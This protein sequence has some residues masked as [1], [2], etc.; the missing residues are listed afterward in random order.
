MFASAP[1][2]RCHEP[3]LRVARRCL[4]CRLALRP[5][6]AASRDD[7]GRLHRSA[8]ILALAA[9]SLLCLGSGGVVAL[10]Y[11][12]ARALRQQLG[13]ER[14]LAGLELIR[15]AQEQWRR[16]N[17]A[18]ASLTQLGDLGLLDPE[19]ISGLRDGY[20][21]E[22]QPLREDPSQ[23]WLGVATPL[24]GVGR[25]FAIDE[26]GAVVYRD[27]PLELDPERGSLPLDVQPL[28]R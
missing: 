9:L 8:L 24:D 16:E 27:G 21:F 11:P 12:E 23:R 5:D 25:A 22:V 7:T 14:A 28:L 2:P 17:P 13:E 20:S 10:L 1:C 18:Y 15:Q 3:V 19:L 4:N 6:P 26:Q